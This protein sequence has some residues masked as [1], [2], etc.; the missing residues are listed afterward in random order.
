MTE[1]FRSRAVDL[2]FDSR[3]RTPSCLKII[4]DQL[5]TYCS[6][7]FEDCSVFYMDGLVSILLCVLIPSSGLN[8]FQIRYTPVP[9]LF[10]MLPLRFLTYF[11]FNFEG[12]KKW[13]RL[14]GIERAAY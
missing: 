3:K 12:S 14:L 9:R 1:L 2:S 4:G 13:R 11:L 10:T 7:S 6:V 5:E 8:F